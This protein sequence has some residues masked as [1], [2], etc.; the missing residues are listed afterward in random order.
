MFYLTL[1]GFYG[2]A[3]RYP[4]MLQNFHAKMDP[5]SGNFIVNLKFY[6][7]K[8][9]ILSEITMGAIQAVPHMYNSVLTLPK[10]SSPGGGATT[11]TEEYTVSKGYQK[12]IELY[13][14][15]KSKGLIEDSFP[16]LTVQQ[17]QK[18]LDNFIQ[19]VLDDFRKQDFTPLTDAERYQKTLADYINDVYFRNTGNKYWFD[20]NI[21]TKNFIVVNNPLNPAQ[22][23]KVY[24]IRAEFSKD[25]TDA[26]GKLLG[27]CEKYN[28][29]LNGT[30]NPTFGLGKTYLINNVNKSY[31]LAPVK[32]NTSNF[33]TEVDFNDVNLEET[34]R[35]QYNAQPYTSDGKTETTD[36][37]NLILKKKW[38][39]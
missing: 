34:Y 8:Y 16:T 19:T 11:A 21:D 18:K 10:T 33:I 23:R 1:K 28:N 17:L 24:S 6:T 13:N 38:L 35:Q 5:G 27:L 9:T 32:I 2:K 15:Y 31:G 39:W 29:E 14:E 37:Y 20:T 30:N 22:K 7:Y 26:V 3:V 12:V 4:L 25:D 36:Y